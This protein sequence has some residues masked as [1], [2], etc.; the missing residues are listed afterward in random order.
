MHACTCVELQVLRGGAWAVL[1]VSGKSLDAAATAAVA[2]QSALRA[3]SLRAEARAADA[4]AE[5][6]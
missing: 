5:L 3:G 4:A 6:E 1:D 2:L